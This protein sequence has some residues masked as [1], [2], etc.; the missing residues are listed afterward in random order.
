MPS[1]T[2]EEAPLLT[3]KE[4]CKLL[5]VSQRFVYRRTERGASDPIPFIRVGGHLRFRRQTIYDWVAER[6]SA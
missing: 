3:V 6:E 1:A 2:T 5:N 4:V